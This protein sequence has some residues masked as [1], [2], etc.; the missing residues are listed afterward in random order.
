MTQHRIYSTSFASVYPH[1]VAKAE[2]KGKTKAQ[3]DQIIRW[4]TGCPSSK[5]LAQ[6]WRGVNGERASSGVGF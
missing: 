1:Y 3:V 5:H 6:V 2:K 4:L